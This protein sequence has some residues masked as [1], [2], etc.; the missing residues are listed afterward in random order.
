MRTKNTWMKRRK[1]WIIGWLWCWVRGWAHWSCSRRRLTSHHSRWLAR[2]VWLAWLWSGSLISLR[3]A[4]DLCVRVCVCVCVRVRVCVCVRVCVRVCVCLCCMFHLL[5]IFLYL[6]HL[7]LPLSLSLSYSQ[8]HMYQRS[9]E[10]FALGSKIDKDSSS[11]SHPPFLQQ[12]SID[13]ISLIDTYSSLLKDQ[14]KEKG[15][16]WEEKDDDS[17]SSSALLNVKRRNH[18][19]ERDNCVSDSAVVRH[20]KRKEKTNKALWGRGRLGLSVGKWVYSIFFYWF[21]FGWFSLI[22]FL[23]V[24]EE[25]GGRVCEGIWLER[26]KGVKDSQKNIGK[27]V[28]E[29]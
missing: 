5:S 13:E 27:V 6:S 25:K 1:S 18:A 3:F 2:R 20:V 21:F 4:F 26:R 7:S 28:R 15:E 8:E 10:C 12:H 22:F 16:R 29:M 17:S 19:R 24:V 23:G 14:A 11:S 9:L